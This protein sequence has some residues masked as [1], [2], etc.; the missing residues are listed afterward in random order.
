VREAGLVERDQVVETSDYSPEGGY[1]WAK[2]L[3]DQHEPPTA[4]ATASDVQAIGVLREISEINLMVGK[5]VA[6][7]GYHDVDLAQYACVTS[8]HLPAYEMG[9]RAVRSLLSAVAQP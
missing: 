6:V 7:I 9:Q 5:D 2:T 1:S 8:V 3:L 4:F